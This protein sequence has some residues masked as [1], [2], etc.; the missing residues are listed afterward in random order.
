MQPKNHLG[1]TLQI[2]SFGTCIFNCIFRRGSLLAYEIKWLD[3][4]EWNNATCSNMDGARDCHT[5]W[6]K[7]D[8]GEIP[9]DIG[10]MGILK[11]NDTNELISK[12]I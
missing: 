6:S 10:Y 4:K 9:H 3:W 5:E 2:L 7:S 8:R 11:R 12:K 1:I